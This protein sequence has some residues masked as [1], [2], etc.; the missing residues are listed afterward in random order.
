MAERIGFIGLGIMGKPMSHNL[1]KA[2]HALVV[3]DIVKPAVDELVAAGARAG[4]SARAVAEASDVIITM[5]PDS[6]QVEDVVF[7]A[8][9]VLEGVRPGQVFVD[10]S[11]ISPIT[12]RKVFDAMKARGV[13]A[14]DAPVSGGQKGAIEATLSIMVG[15][16]REAFDRVLPLFQVMGKNITH[17]AEDPGAG[18]VTKAANQIIVALNIM[19]VAEALTLA[20]KAGVDPAKVRQALMGGFAHSRILELHGQRILDRA[21]EPGF[22]IRLHI[23]DLGIALATGKAHGVPLFATS[24]MHEVLNALMAQGDGELDHS[25][26]ARFVERAAGLG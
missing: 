9:G 13:P 1:L 25:A 17:I 2:G 7:G 6:P 11:T 15:G 26:I 12:S 8:G 21:F 16:P 14:L 18:Q 23:K 24:L 5:L 10:M 3:H 4:G 19:A 20:R 22:R